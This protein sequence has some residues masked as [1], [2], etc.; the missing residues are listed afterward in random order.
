MHVVDTARI[1]AESKAGNNMAARMAMMAMTTN[2]SINV[3]PRR[4]TSMSFLPPLGISIWI[5]FMRLFLFACPTALMSGWAGIWLFIRLLFNQPEERARAAG[6]IV[7]LADKTIGRAEPDTPV[8]S[9]SGDDSLPRTGHVAGHLQAGA[10]TAQP[11]YWNGA[12]RHGAN[13]QITGPIA[14]DAEV[15]F[16][17]LIAERIGRKDIRI[18]RGCTNHPFMVVANASLIVKRTIIC[19]GRIYAILV[20]NLG[21]RTGG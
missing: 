16:N 1:L 9:I 2:N 20:D 3:N 17:I 5:F 8:G 19:P 6:R 14:A 18:K 7:C 13:G 11:R 12:S 15:G 21:C 4:R 10:W